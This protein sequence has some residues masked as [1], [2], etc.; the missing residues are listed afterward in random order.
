M[1][2]VIPPCSRSTVHVFPRKAD[3]HT[4][5]CVCRRSTRTCRDNLAFYSL[6]RGKLL[7]HSSTADGALC[8]PRSRDLVS[9]SGLEHCMITPAFE[10]GRE[11]EPGGILRFQGFDSEVDHTFLFLSSHDSL[12]S[13]IDTCSSTGRHQRRRRRRSGRIRIHR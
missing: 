7:W 2:G 6:T 4:C 10:E 13:L 3:E 1:H 11:M 9:P 5:L 12:L 8:R